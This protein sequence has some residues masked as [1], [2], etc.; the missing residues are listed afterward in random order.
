MPFN[1]DL[2]DE[3][4]ILIKFKACSSLEGIKVHKTAASEVIAATDR[5]YEKGMVTKHDG[6]F[7]TPLGQEAAELT[8]SLHTMLSSSR[9]EH[10]TGAKT[11]DAFN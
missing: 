5:L 8:Q 3:M 4:N 9:E 11:A 10:E 1:Q 6:G 7:L 2:V